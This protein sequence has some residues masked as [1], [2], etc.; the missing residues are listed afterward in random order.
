VEWLAQCGIKTVAMEA[1]GVYWI[2]LYELLEARGLEAVLVN[3]R[4]LHSVGGRKSDVSDSQWLQQLHSVGLLKP[5]FRPAAVL[6]PLRA[7]LCQRQRAWSRKTR[8]RFSA[9]RKR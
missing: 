8:G 9:C 5:S 7:Y 2:A 6:V 1:T 3:A 4:H